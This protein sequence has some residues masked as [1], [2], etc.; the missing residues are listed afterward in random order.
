[1]SQFEEHRLAAALHWRAV[2]L[3]SMIVVHLAT[4]AFTA[5][6]AM[7]TFIAEGKAIIEATSAAL[8]VAFLA[9]VPTTA[10]V[11]LAAPLWVWRAHANLRALGLP[12]LVHAPLVTAASWFIPL[13]G[14]VVP[15]LAMRE[16]WNRSMGE[17]Q[18]QAGAQVAAVSGWWACLIGGALL[19]AIFV[20]T[21]Y[22]SWVPGLRVT[23]SPF[24]LLIIGVLGTVLMIAA[25]GF[26]WVLV[27]RITQGQKALVLTSGVF[28]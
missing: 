13:I 20:S 7:W 17:D 25:Y 21:L 11:L 4:T 6:M 9:G 14:L 8:I 22:L 10:L 26:L 16:L 19:Q 1:M 28:A 12:G 18:Y 24:L 2:L 23:T 5:C 27:R 3:Q 15:P